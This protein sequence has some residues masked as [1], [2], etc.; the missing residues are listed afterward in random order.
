[1]TQ[2]KTLHVSNVSIES[3]DEQLQHLFE[4]HGT[5]VKCVIIRNKFNMVP[6]GFG[7]VEFSSRKNCL[8]ALEALNGYQYMNQVLTVSLAIPPASR[9]E[10]LQKGGRPRSRFTTPQFDQ[11]YYN[12]GNWDW[13]SQQQQTP[14]Y[15]YYP[16]YHDPPQVGNRFFPY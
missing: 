10:R 13:G 11:Y 12:P 6:R 15:Y 3:S 2:V 1:M 16:P 9:S 5:V 14:Q 8:E 4:Q 7:F